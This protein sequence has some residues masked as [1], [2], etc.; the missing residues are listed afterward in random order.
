MKKD[1]LF[2]PKMESIFNGILVMILVLIIN[3]FKFALRFFQLM[4]HMGGN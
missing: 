1:A 4:S 3:I 2:K